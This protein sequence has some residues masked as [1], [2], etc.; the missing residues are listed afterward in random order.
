MTALSRV[1]VDL[2]EGL[3]NGSSLAF[4]RL[5][6]EQGNRMKSIAANMLRSRSEA[7]DAVHDAF[8][9][10]FRGAGQFDGRCP[11]EHWLIRI[12]VNT[13]RD[14]IRLRRPAGPEVELQRAPREDHALRMALREAI[15]QLPERQRTVFLLHSVEGLR[16]AE[17]A[18]ILDE[19]EGTVRGVLFEARKRLRSILRPAEAGS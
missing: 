4:E 15:A 12:L 9:K 14:R 13:C 10:A 17:I 18:S 1:E 19:A 8:V 7:E 6:R 2:A 3:R 5:Y 16:H 11:A